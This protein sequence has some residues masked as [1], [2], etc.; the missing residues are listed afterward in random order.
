MILLTALLLAATPARHGTWVYPLN[1]LPLPDNTPSGKV[2]NTA[3]NYRL[4][5][6]YVSLRALPP[7]DS[8]TAAYITALKNAGLRVE[9]LLSDPNVEPAVQRVLTYNASQPPSAQFDG[10]H[11]DYEPWI[12]TGNDTSWVVP[13]LDV[14]RRA[15]AML[16]NTNMSMSGDISAVKYDMLTSAQR[17]DLLLAATRL[18]MMAY[19]MTMDKILQRA[20][21]WMTPLACTQGDI[22]IAIRTADFGSARCTLCNIFTDFEARYETAPQFAGTAIFS[23][24]TLV[25][26]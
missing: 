16:V 6:L 4:T 3:V 20:D 24:G 15:K 14:Y 18:T 22:V 1:N 5:E 21:A 9:A 2:I 8:R 25:Q 23:F 11:Y 13:L 10:I 7:E 26:P 19:E 17:L 12:G